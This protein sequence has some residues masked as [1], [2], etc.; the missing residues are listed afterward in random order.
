MRC[1]LCTFIIL[2][3]KP[4]NVLNGLTYL[5]TAIN[6]LQLTMH[7]IYENYF[8][9]QALREK[10]SIFPHSLYFPHFVSL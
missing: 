7:C 5:E 1:Y 3:I 4:E 10:S 8:P 6:P 9:R 2:K